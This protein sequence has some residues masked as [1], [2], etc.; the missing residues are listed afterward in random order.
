MLFGQADPPGVPKGAT[1]VPAGALE[2]PQR[3]PMGL[4]GSPKGG[5]EVAHGTSRQP[6]CLH[7][8]LQMVSLGVRICVFDLG[9]PNPGL[10]FRALDHE[11][12]QMVSLGV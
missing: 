9:S 11:E 8:Q 10:R 1:E 5:T 4:P 3:C 6:R 7:E 12:L 2:E